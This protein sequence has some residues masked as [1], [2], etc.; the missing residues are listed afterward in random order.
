[1]NSMNVNCY[2]WIDFNSKFLSQFLLILVYL[3]FILSHPVNEIY[4]IKPIYYF[5][6]GAGVILDDNNVS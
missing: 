1:M 5:C 6:G 2:L 4:I 3:R